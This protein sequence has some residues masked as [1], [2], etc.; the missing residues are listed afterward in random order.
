M[1]M[2]R[3]E[4]GNQMQTISTMLENG[5]KREQVQE[6]MDGIM[7]RLRELKSRRQR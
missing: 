1:G 3:H 7:E 4:L 6:M 5:V 2:V